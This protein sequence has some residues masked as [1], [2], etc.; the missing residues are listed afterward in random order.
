MPARS[1][2]ITSA[3]SIKYY[4]FHSIYYGRSSIQLKDLLPP[5]I[6]F[7]PFTFIPEFPDA[8]SWPN[9]YSFVNYTD[10]V[11]YFRVKSIIEKINEIHHITINSIKNNYIFSNF[12]TNWPWGWRLLQVLMGDKTKEFR[13]SFPII[14]KNSS[15]KF[16]MK[17][18]KNLFFEIEIPSIFLE[19]KT[20]LRK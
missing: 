3:S 2:Y 18:W 12:R 1:H 9:S 7:S 14:K 5:E 13:I 20:H 10:R 4:N 16:K 11:T 15:T 6:S 17:H 19:N 8:W